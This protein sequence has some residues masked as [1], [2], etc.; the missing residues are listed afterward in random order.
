MQYILVTPDVSLDKIC[1][2]DMI[3][4]D[5][6]KEYS[7]DSQ[8]SVTFCSILK[9]YIRDYELQHVLICHSRKYTIK[10]YLG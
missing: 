4:M 6:V 9:K 8:E 7:T 3:A 2:Q 1:Y 10:I 5:D